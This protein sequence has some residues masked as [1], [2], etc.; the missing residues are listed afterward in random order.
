MHVGLC[1]KCL[2]LMCDFNQ[3]WNLL[4]DF[5]KTPQCKISL[6]SGDWFLSC[7]MQTDG[8]ID[9]AKLTSTI[10]QLL[11][12]NMPKSSSTHAHANSGVSRVWEYGRV[13]K[14]NVLE[15]NQILNSES[16][17]ERFCTIYTR[18]YQLLAYRLNAVYRICT[19][20]NIWP[21][22]PCC[23]AIIEELTVAQLVKKFPAFMESKCSLPDSQQPALSWAR[24]THCT[25]SYSG[26]Q[27]PT[28]IST[29]QVNLPFCWYGHPVTTGKWTET[30]FVRSIP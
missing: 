24:G 16:K 18:V 3:H 25:S 28:L 19:I 22:T 11:T 29:S 9:M 21:P 27:W 1:G 8:M 4:T 17:F 10:L 23:R 14:I 2:F 15:I 6:K 12:D 7:Y 26:P 30:V 20:Y 5:S 13:W